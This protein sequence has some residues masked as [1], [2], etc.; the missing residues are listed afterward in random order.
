MKKKTTMKQQL[1]IAILHVILIRHL[2]GQRLQRKIFFLQRTWKLKKNKKTW[3]WNTF[4][5]KWASWNILS[6]QKNVDLSAGEAPKTEQKIKQI[7]FRES[8]RNWL[9]W[10]FLYTARCT[11]YSAIWYD[12]E[13]R[14]MMWIIKNVNVLCGKMYKI[15]KKN[16]CW[17]IKFLCT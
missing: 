3:D 14:G 12:S 11:I 1:Q 4:P 8:T 10:N 15:F 13:W 16:T 7:W 2:Y 9:R 17:A 5:K 6:V